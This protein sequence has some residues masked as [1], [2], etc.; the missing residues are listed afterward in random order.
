MFHAAAAER[1]LDA[2]IRSQLD[3]LIEDHVARGIP[4]DKAERLA[5]VEFGGVDQVKEAV[6]SVR[7]AAW[8]DELARDVRYGYRS[9][10]RN[11][12]FT[13]A[14]IL[15][16]A[17]GIGVN[18]TIF[19]IVNGI[20]FRT[21]RVPGEERIVSISQLFDGRAINR[22]IRLERSWFSY[23]EYEAY[24][25]GNHT[26]SGLLAYAPFVTATLGGEQPRL[27]TGALTSCNYF[28][29]L[30]VPLA[31]GRGFAPSD[32]AG[33]G[34][35]AVAVLSD[36]VWR[37]VFGAD[38]TLVGRFVTFNRSA[39]RVI[40][41]APRGFGPTGPVAAAF[42]VPLTMQ[43]SVLHTETWL[44]DGNASWLAMLGRAR[45]DVSRAHVRADLDV[46]AA[47][48]DQ[49]QPKRKT[50]LVVRT[51]TMFD[52]PQA[53]TALLGIGS[54]LLGAV[55][56]VLLVACA[57]VANMLLARSASRRRE[58]AVRLALGASRSRL[59]RQLLTESALMAVAGGLVGSLAALWSSAA[60][61]RILLGHLPAQIPPLALVVGPDLRVVSYGAALTI[62]TV[63]AAGL[64]PALRASRPDLTTELKQECGEPGGRSGTRTLLRHWLLGWQVTVSTVLVLVTGLLLRGW[65]QAETIDP[66]FHTSDVAVASY[67]L[68]GAGYNDQAA[69]AFQQH[70]TARLSAMP[71]TTTAL[72][73]ITP[74]RGRLGERF[75]TA[76]GTQ[77]FGDGNVISHAYFS[78]LQIP[79]VRGRAF[80]ATDERQH[81]GV[82]IVSESTARRL[83]PG[84]DPIG[85]TLHQAGPAGVGDVHEVIGVAK[86]AQVSYL[87]QSDQTY[88]YFPAS[89][90]QQS[91]LIVMVRRAGD[92]AGLAA[93]IRAAFRDVDRQLVVDVRKL[94]DNIELWRTVSRLAVSASATL[95]ILALSLALI[96]A[97]GV[98]AYTVARR[99]REI[100]IRVAL[101]ATRREVIRTILRQTMRPV[102]AGALVGLLCTA[103]VSRLLSSVLFGVSPYDPVAFVGVSIF[104]LVV[105]AMAAYLPARS[106]ARVDPLIA[107]RYE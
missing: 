54:L 42:W 7:T 15:T 84:L 104:L 85:Q 86:D 14:A 36:E 97:Y 94:D 60:I 41:I 67:D 93:D 105:A 95:G 9:L 73:W 4:R 13:T 98:V 3:L 22:R 5:R 10:R 102:L 80:T 81:P 30:E 56:L 25:D 66:G 11:P 91:H 55:T 29:V 48:I 107:L 72:A 57:N 59:V 74:L 88:V 90:E 78:L 35:N 26:L 38:P 83:W 61:V 51:A 92:F 21:L 47:Q 53:R 23:P 100:G 62:L 27:L 46:I 28:D 12:G 49:Q 75:L 58:I 99:T 39:F 45:E 33:P 96:G 8:I 24:R 106:A 19:T 64:A 17:L 63:V 89:P 37:T 65:Y 101:G 34:T 18:V 50:T 82:V 103:A 16:I 70:L 68:T 20:V 6:R 1:D 44:A 71:G 43:A 40:G 32:C 31:L 76:D 52:M 69:M 77:H 79:I 2:E 87:A